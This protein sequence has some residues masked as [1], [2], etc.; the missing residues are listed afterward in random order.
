MGERQG[1]LYVRS[2]ELGLVR[3]QFHQ[4]RH[5]CLLVGTTV[6]WHKT[7]IW[8]HA[9]T[10]RYWRKFNIVVDNERCKNILTLILAVLSYWLQSFVN[11]QAA[12]KRNSARQHH[13]SKASSRLPNMA[14]YITS[15]LLHKKTGSFYNPQCNQYHHTTKRSVGVGYIFPHVNIL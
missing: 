5:T 2:D 4:L 3:N 12:H 10:S 14:L 15:L 6:M 7:V 9:K 11:F 13:F 1:Q 8:P